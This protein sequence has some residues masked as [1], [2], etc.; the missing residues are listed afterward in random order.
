MGWKEYVPGYSSQWCVWVLST[1]FQWAAEMLRWS[2]LHTRGF[3]DVSSLLVR[4]TVIEVQMVRT[5]WVPE[6]WTPAQGLRSEK[7]SPSKMKTNNHNMYWMT[8]NCTELICPGNFSLNWNTYKQTTIFS[9]ILWLT[10]YEVMRPRVNNFIVTLRRSG[11]KRVHSCLSHFHSREGVL[12]MKDDI[13]RMEK[14]NS[15]Q[16]PNL[17]ETSLGN[18]KFNS[19][20]NNFECTKQPEHPC[21]LSIWV[22]MSTPP[23][24]HFSAGEGW[25][26]IKFD[27]STS[28]S[29]P[30]AM[31]LYRV[32]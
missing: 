30:D 32:F 2:C 6:G 10:W 28:F 5:P 14:D 18:Y 21:N 13:Q 12:V 24:L 1:W 7:M 15:F 29:H 17:R 8:L 16:H 19:F 3:S 4:K 11:S 31:V 25:G 9:I 26:N 23:T 27:C 22:D 20:G